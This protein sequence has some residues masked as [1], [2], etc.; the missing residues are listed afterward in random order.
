MTWNWLAVRASER[1]VLDG[2]KEFRGDLRE[3]TEADARKL[4]TTVRLALFFRG[5]VKPVGLRQAP[6]FSHNQERHPRHGYSGVPTQRT[7][8]GFWGAS[9]CATKCR[10]AVMVACELTEPSTIAFPAVDQETTTFENLGSEEI[11]G[12]RMLAVRVAARRLKVPGG[13]TARQVKTRKG[14]VIQ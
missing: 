8:S 9:V 11:H 7:N 10:S 14:R 2:T 13:K 12:V 6:A 3:T 5:R 1:D 4:E